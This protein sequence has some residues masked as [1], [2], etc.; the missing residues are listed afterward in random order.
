M[1]EPF[2]VLA[3][4]SALIRQ[5]FLTGELTDL[6]AGR[7]LAELVHVDE[8]GRQ[9]TVGATTGAWYMRYRPTDPWRAALPPTLTVDDDGSDGEQSVTVVD[10]AGTAAALADSD[11]AALLA[12]TEPADTDSWDPVTPADDVTGDASSF[13]LPAA[14]PPAD[15]DWAASGWS[16]HGDGPIGDVDAVSAALDNGDLTADELALLNTIATHTDHTHWS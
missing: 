16:L 12:A 3:D 7:R 9:W 5:R 15:D 8:H 4:T 14:T 11:L 2:E 13:S 1:P 10:T 6:E